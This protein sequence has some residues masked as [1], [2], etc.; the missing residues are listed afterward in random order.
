MGRLEEARE[1]V[2]RGLE[3]DPHN[4]MFQT[5]LGTILYRSRRYDDAIE[6][7]RK[8]LSIEPNFR[9][10]RG[11]LAAAYHE[12]R[13]FEEAFREAK[14]AFA[15]R[16]DHELVQALE[17]GYEDDGYHGAMRLAADTL[18]ARSTLVDAMR[19][20]RLYTYAGDKERALEWL[21]RAYEARLHNMIY[22][23]VNPQWDPLRSDPRFQDLLRRMNFPE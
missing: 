22:L 14:A 3:I 20:A 16:D 8:G 11:G 21:G 15:L 13:L 23:S 17:R 12:K 2:E 5:Y 4:F 1:Q 6:Q 9:D 18:A 19:I 7:Y 10:A